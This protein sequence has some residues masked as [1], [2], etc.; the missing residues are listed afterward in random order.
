MFMNSVLVF[1]FLFFSEYAT[2][3]CLLSQRENHTDNHFAKNSAFCILSKILS[4]TKI[5]LRL[6]DIF[7]SQ[8]LSHAFI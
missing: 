6:S 3:P 4:S 7:S 5:I 2:K 8:L 1:F